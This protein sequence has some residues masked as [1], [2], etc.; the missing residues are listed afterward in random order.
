MRSSTDVRVGQLWRCSDPRRFKICRVVAYDSPTRPQFRVVFPFT[1]KMLNI[2][3]G[4][5]TTLHRSVFTL[6]GTH[7]WSL[8][9]NV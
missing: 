6:T 1:V 4:A 5:L 9:R 8:E 3:T 2:V 7:G